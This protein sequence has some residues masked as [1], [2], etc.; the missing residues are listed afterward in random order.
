MYNI[1]Y[2][3]KYNLSERGKMNQEKNTMKEEMRLKNMLCIDL[4][5]F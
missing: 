2:G 5:L 3:A 4:N 1:K